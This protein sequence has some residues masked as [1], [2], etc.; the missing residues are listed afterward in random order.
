MEVLVCHIKIGSLTVDFVHEVT[1]EST[2]KELTQK[3][4]ILLPAA[5]KVDKNKLKD[6]I[7]KGTEVSIQIGYES[8]G[9]QEIFK[10]ISSQA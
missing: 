5:L 2:W 1:V 7:P 4:T 6:A 3:A 8:E 9:L 10:K